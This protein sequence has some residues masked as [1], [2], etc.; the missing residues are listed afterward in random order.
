MF[1]L[2]SSQTRRF[3]D[4]KR[5]N[6]VIKSK[7]SFIPRCETKNSIFSSFSKLAEENSF[8]RKKFQSSRDEKLKKFLNSSRNKESSD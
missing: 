2:N 1:E 6:S 8:L 5:V 7:T 3:V 4:R